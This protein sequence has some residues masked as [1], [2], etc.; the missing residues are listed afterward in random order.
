GDIRF[1]I[2]PQNFLQRERGDY[3]YNATDTFLHD[4]S[5][6]FNERSVGSGFYSGNEKLL[7]LFA[8][9]DWRFRD[10]LTLNLGVNYAFQQVPAGAKQQALNAIASVPG[11][12][13]FR[14][15]RSQKKNFGPR[16]GIAYSPKYDSGI[17]AKIFGTNSQSAIRAGF[18]MSYDILFD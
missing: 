8:Q 9:D 1:I 10:N 16:I 17:M 2:S 15:P 4:I 14:E 5:A 7:F 18:S 12:I 3:E 11:L 13:D 6:E